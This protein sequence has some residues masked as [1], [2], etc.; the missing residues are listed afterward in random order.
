MS[1][2]S[3]K[4]QIM[5]TS[6]I[7]IAI[8][9][10]LGLTG[11]LSSINIQDTGKMPAIMLQPVGASPEGSNSVGEEVS[12]DD[13]GGAQQDDTGDQSSEQD[14]AN[15]LD[16]ETRSND[17]PELTP[18]PTSQA[19]T[20]KGSPQVQDNTLNGGGGNI[21]ARDCPDKGPIP[22]D[23]TL[24]PFPPTPPKCPDKGPIPPDCT[25]NPFPLLQEDETQGGITSTPTP[26]P[27]PTIVAPLPTL[28]ESPPPTIPNLCAN[29]PRPPFCPPT[30]NPTIAPNPTL[31]APN[32]NP[33]TNERGLFGAVPTG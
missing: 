15:T 33:T 10:S 17:S 26:T 20:G 29:T 24:N 19:F 23:C 16:G 32:N 3:K 5:V 7:M 11:I 1:G 30:P 21:I 8:V 9:S 27:S 25:L 31:I 4:L 18:F 13:E 28:I 2:S 12:G 22:P 6:L 14:N